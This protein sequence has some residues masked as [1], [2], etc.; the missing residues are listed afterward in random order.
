KVWTRVGRSNGTS[1]RPWLLLTPTPSWI[2]QETNLSTILTPGDYT[3]PSALVAGT[4]PDMPPE[5]AGQ[6]FTL[7][8]EGVNTTLTAHRLNQTLT[9]LPYAVGK[10]PREF[11][12]SIQNSSVYVDWVETGADSAISDLKDDY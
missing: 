4:I 3:A 10:P 11:K 5:V 8:V 7:R 9:T 1:W 2:S 6:P 12:R